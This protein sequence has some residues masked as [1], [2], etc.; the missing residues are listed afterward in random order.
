MIILLNSPQPI[1]R[2]L[3]LSDGV[4]SSPKLLHARPAVL[5]Q[6]L[7]NHRHN[8]FFFINTLIQLLTSVQTHTHRYLITNTQ[9][10]RQGLYNHKHEIH[11]VHVWQARQVEQVL[12]GGACK[13]GD[14]VYYT[15][16]IFQNERPGCLRGLLLPGEDSETWTT[17]GMLLTGKDSMG[18]FLSYRAP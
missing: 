2:V 4:T 11:V 18:P 8:V 14:Q 17:A 3:P 6:G 15:S 9:A 13:S 12:L 10:Q 1:K 5:G 16:S 7:L